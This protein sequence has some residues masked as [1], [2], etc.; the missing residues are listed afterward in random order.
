M[1]AT[2]LGS[3]NYLSV[4]QVKEYL[5]LRQRNVKGKLTGHVSRISRS[6]TKRGR[7]HAP[8]LEPGKRGEESAM[9]AGGKRGRWN[10]RIGRIN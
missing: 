6:M 3:K 5:G 2:H 4:N 1:V 7:Q 8:E 10:S 9:E